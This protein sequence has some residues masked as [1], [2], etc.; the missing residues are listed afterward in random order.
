MKES[1]SLKKHPFP[2]QYWKSTCTFPEK[3]PIP[4]KTAGTVASLS[5]KR[6]PFTS[7]MLEKDLHFP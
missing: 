4:L 2:L 6:H 3:A 5:L 7:K 1:V